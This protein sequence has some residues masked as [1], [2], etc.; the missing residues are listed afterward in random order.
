MITSQHLLEGSIYALKQCGHLL[1]SAIT[2]FKDGD[3]SAAIAVATFGNEELG[4]SRILRR[5]W[6]EVVQ[7]SKT[8]TIE[9]LKNYLQDHV[10]KLEV[11]QTGVAIRASLDQGLG[12]QL[13]TLLH[14]RP[15]SEKYQEAEKIV[16]DASQRKKN[17]TPDDRHRMRLRSLY[18]DPND[19]G[20]SW[21]KPW[22]IS[23]DEA[24]VFLEDVLN[25]YGMELDPF[26]HLDILDLKY[27]EFAKA[28]RSWT[29][30]PN[31]LPR[32]ALV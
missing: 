26:N 9:D 4:R 1:Q 25:D 14:S 2:L 5:L 12:Q 11:A 13:R 6:H 29:D 10:K 17:R 20:T 22:E 8:L 27:P 18:V 3:Y 28:Y 15:D 32:P 21:N 30:R 19:S 7:G 31:L 23:C 24:K 16:N